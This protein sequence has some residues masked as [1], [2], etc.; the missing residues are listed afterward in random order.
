MRV[1]VAALGICAVAFFA[2]IAG[3]LS[4]AAQ[5]AP[6]TGESVRLQIPADAVRAHPL[7]VVAA[8]HHV[9]RHHIAR[10]RRAHAKPHRAHKTEPKL[11]L[12]AISKAALSLDDFS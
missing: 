10:T 4:L 3:D 2:G 6:T 5:P 1:V 8:A 11:D 7:P 9:R 12:A